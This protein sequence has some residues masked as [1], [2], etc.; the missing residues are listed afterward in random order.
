MPIEINEQEFR[1]YLTKTFSQNG[2]SAHLNLEKVDKFLLLTKRM[3]EENEKYNL[4]AITE[5]KKIILNHYADCVALAK[6]IKKGASVID[7]GC[8]AGF[9]TLP[10]A[11]VRDD[12]KIV[13]M[14]STEKRVNYV[15]ETAEMLGLNNVT[16][17][18]MRAEDGAKLPEYREKF[19]YATARAVAELRILSELCL[20]Y[21]KLSGKLLA[22]KGKNAEFELSGA[23]KALAVLGGKNPT[24][25]IITLKAD[26]QE[27]LTH[28]I[29]SVEKGTKTPPAYPRPYA[30]ISK[31]P[32]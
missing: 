29:I 22:M 16:A 23:K 2:L 20:P 10:L 31:K 8:G 11:L 9:P 1:S 14:D 5:P 7:I 30:Q 18:T 21:V 32:L 6:E 4:T 12:I 17:V 27:P 3:L 19:D 28:P 13:A 25:N 15:R 26:G 24:A